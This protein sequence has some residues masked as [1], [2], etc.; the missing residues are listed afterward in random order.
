MA[1]FLAFMGS[2]AIIK[3]QTKLMV[4]QMT[5]LDKLANDILVAKDID[6]L[7]NLLL[8]W[9]KENKLHEA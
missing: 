8:Q 3:F 2:I 4:S 1:Y 5:R 9:A 7:R 6:D